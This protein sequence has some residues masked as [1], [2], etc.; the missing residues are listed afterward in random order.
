M[1]AAGSSSCRCGGA[2]GAPQIAAAVKRRALWASCAA[3][4]A[5]VVGLLP[6]AFCPACYPALAGLLGALGLGATA[7]KS[8]APVTAI[9]LLLAL[10]GLTY[11]AKRNRNYRPLALGAL[12]AV[13][14]YAGQFLLASAMIKL[15]GI[16]VL[17]AASFWNILQRRK[18][19]E[20]ECPDCAEGR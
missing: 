2:P 16:V 5:A 7:E 10:L 17:M 8:L 3:L 15:S 11:Q 19:F 18:G 9:L 20:A 13:A 1:S 4:P 14:I 6:A 12:G